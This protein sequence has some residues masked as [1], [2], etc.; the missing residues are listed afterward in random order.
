M[1]NKTTTISGRQSAGTFK[2]LRLHGHW[3]I[4][5]ATTRGRKSGIVGKMSILHDVSDTSGGGRGGHDGRYTVKSDDSYIK[6]AS[7]SEF[8][9][10]H[11]L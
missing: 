10:E 6:N 4:D 2:C 7:W 3:N 9:K 11:A 8:G 5:S 1:F